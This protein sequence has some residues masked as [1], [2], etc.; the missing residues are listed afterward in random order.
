MDA[1]LLAAIQ[2]GRGL[3]KSP[4]RPSVA[5]ARTS[6]AAPAKVR[7]SHS[8]AFDSIERPTRRLTP[9]PGST[10]GR[11]TA[12]PLPPLLSIESLR[13]GQGGAT[14]T[15]PT[16]GEAKRGTAQGAT[17]TTTASTQGKAAQTATESE[18]RACATKAEAKACGTAATEAEAG[19]TR[20][21]TT[22]TKTSGTGTAT[23]ETKTSGTG[24][25]TTQACATQACATQACA[26]AQGRCTPS[27]IATQASGPHTTTTCTGENALVSGE[28]A[29]FL[30]RS[31][32][33]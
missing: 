18:A 12:L 30:C 17:T 1:S 29:R 9:N 8:T 26:K 2:K 6:V 33:R 24:T 21:T 4:R 11:L 32:G 20:A 15:G 5:T 31:E 7:N 23:T 10:I 13:S 28:E 25:T 19:R 27:A 14:A 22:E 3:K 16:A